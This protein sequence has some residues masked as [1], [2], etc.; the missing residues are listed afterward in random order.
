MHCMWQCTLVRHNKS[1]AVQRMFIKL[2][3]IGPQLWVAWLVPLARRPPGEIGAR[4][5]EL[6]AILLQSKGK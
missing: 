3:Q 5:E 4:D 1:L 2:V 6:K